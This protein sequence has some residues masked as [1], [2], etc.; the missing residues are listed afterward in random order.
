M[1]MT[2]DAQDAGR[3]LTGWHVLAIFVGAFGIIIG[4]NVF[5]AFKAVG[6]FPGLETKN[7]YVASQKFDNDRAA[8]AALGW[9]VSPTMTGETLML[10]ITDEATGLP[11][12]VREIGGVLGRATHVADDREPFFTRTMSG[13]YKAEVGALDYGKWELRLEAVAEDGTPFRQ[14]IELY[15]PKY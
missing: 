3:K 10:M 12:R 14:L 6:T 9:D 4:V 13:A 2:H 11:V 7:P 8:Q 5:M 1:T 15:V